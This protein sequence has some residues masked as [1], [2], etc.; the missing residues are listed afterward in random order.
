VAKGHH[1]KGWTTPFAKQSIW[2]TFH[3]NQIRNSSAKEWKIHNHFICDGAVQQ[4]IQPQIENIPYHP[5]SPKRQ[6]YVLDHNEFVS[7]QT[8][9][10]PLEAFKKSSIFHGQPTHYSEF[11]FT[12]HQPK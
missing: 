7:T 3:Q 4:I 8:I 6:L 2:W 12:S 5:Y 11:D 10:A 9:G 1:C